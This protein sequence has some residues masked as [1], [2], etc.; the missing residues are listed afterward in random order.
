MTKWQDV[1]VAMNGTTKLVK[2]F[3]LLFS[4]RR[5]NGF[6][7]LVCIGHSFSIYMYP[8]LINSAYKLVKFK[9]IWSLSFV[10]VGPK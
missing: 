10:S 2:L 9:F 5:K 4:R 8:T 3:H 7:I 1:M 6:V